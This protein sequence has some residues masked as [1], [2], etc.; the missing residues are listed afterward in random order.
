MSNLRDALLSGGA[1]SLLSPGVRLSITDSYQCPDFKADGCLLTDCNLTP[2]AEMS[3]DTI[4]KY[5]PMNNG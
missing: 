1:D 3:E 4:C 5:C 2:T